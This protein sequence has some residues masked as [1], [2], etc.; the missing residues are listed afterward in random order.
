LLPEAVPLKVQRYAQALVRQYD[1]NGDGVLD[2]QEWQEMHGKPA[3]A[4]AD[5]DGALTAEELVDWIVAYGHNRRIRLAIPAIGLSSD[6]KT[7]DG[8]PAKTGTASAAK[9]GDSAEAAPAEKDYAEPDLAE[10]DESRRQAKFYVPSK[11][12]PAG[13]PAWFLARDD[14]GDGQLSLGE[15]APKPT[16][17]DLREFEQYDFNNDGLITAKECLRAIKPTKASAK[18]SPGK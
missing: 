13:L 16:P 12:L 2:A 15:F 5:R 14:D 7:E 3:L 11:R 6:S 4:D 17:A 8:T 18:K 1:R 9:P 10:L